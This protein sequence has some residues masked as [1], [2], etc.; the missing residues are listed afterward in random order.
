MEQA[1]KIGAPGPK[2]DGPGTPWGVAWQM[3]EKHLA[4]ND[5]LKFRLK[6]VPAKCKKSAGWQTEEYSQ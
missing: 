6:K 5:D 2:S 3:N 4:W 1:F